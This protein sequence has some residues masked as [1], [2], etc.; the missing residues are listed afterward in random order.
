[1]W[2]WLLSCCRAV[3]DEFSPLLEVG[4]ATQPCP[5]SRTVSILALE[6]QIVGSDVELVAF[7]RPYDA[8]GTYAWS[9]VSGTC[10]LS[11]KQ[12]ARITAVRETPGKVQVQVT[13]AVGDNRSAPEL[14]TM[15]FMAPPIYVIGAGAAGIKAASVLLA[16]GFKVVLCEATNMIGGRARTVDALGGRFK[17]DLGCN[18]L[19]GDE[20]R[21]ELERVPIK[22]LGFRI[23]DQ[24]AAYPQLQKSWGFAEDV[25]AVMGKCDAY[26]E[27]MISGKAEQAA[28]AT[29][30]EKTHGLDPEFELIK[31]KR[32]KSLALKLA[33][34]RAE[35]AVQLDEENVRQHA[36][37]LARNEAIAK[38]S[39]EAVNIELRRIGELKEAPSAAERKEY[40]LLRARV[41]KELKQKIQEQFDA[42]IRNT[43]PSVFDAVGAQFDKARR[44]LREKAIEHTRQELQNACEE[45]ITTSLDGKFSFAEMCRQA[46]QIALAKEGPL[47]EALEY[48]QFS[49]YDRAQEHDPDMKQSDDDLDDVPESDTDNFREDAGLDASA[50]HEE[51][52]EPAN[53]A[54]STLKQSGDNAW[55]L[56]GYGG[57]IASY[58]A[59]LQTRYGAKFLIRRNTAVSSVT[60]AEGKLPKLVL[61]GHASA[62]SA[63]GVVV[64]VSA[65]VI[66]A[67]KL[68]FSGPGAQQ[69]HEDYEFILMGN[70]KK[71]VLVFDRDA[72]MTPVDGRKD[73]STHRS[74]SV[75]WHLD[76]EEHV[77]KFIVPDSFRQVVIAIVG[78]KLATLL[79]DR[80]DEDA[81]RAM[82]SELVALEIVDKASVIEEKFVTNWRKEE[83]FL[84]AYS[85][86]APGGGGRRKSLM[87]Q[88]LGRYGVVLAGEALNDEY[89]SAHA[90]FLSGE[91]AANAIASVLPRLEYDSKQ[92]M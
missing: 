39:S 85:S 59:Y 34:Q 33:Q 17:V 10:V 11:S 88:T 29:L 41:S 53:D 81:V 14:H 63:S 83:A 8:G 4:S 50:D 75:Y 27:E 73:D 79:D 54:S 55:Y 31:R 2:D 49:N 77:W 66:N 9:V 62:I 71:I 23:D 32:I 35:E 19:H 18:W 70:Y 28:A 22:N 61:D 84:G 5:L 68:R 89:G 69:V 21:W 51:D 90:A 26:V 3:D 15:H 65:G 74:T 44:E 13:Y 64:T 82:H 24:R 92:N 43:S 40:A 25:A 60:F 48:E 58:A 91:R 78:G 12:G 52:S 87:Q 76:R 1:M 16:Q 30:F 80:G 20:W 7:G 38:V 57:L 42:D 46:Y 67:G 72:I 56:G 37:E 6:E 47:E 45:E 36:I 86:T